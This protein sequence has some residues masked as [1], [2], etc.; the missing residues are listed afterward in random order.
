MIGIIL[1]AFTAVALRGICASKNL[2]AKASS[3]N[4]VQLSSDTPLFKNNDLTNEIITLPNGYFVKI[5]NTTG[6]LSRVEYN[7]I[8]GYIDNSS[9][10]P[11]S[12]SGTTFQTATLYTR[13]DAGTHLRIKPSATSERV[14]LIPAGSTL[15]YI[16]KTTGDIPSD[17]TS[18]EWYYV[19]FDAGDTTTHTGY[20]YSE[21]TI[22]TNISPKPTLSTI[23]TEPTI[24]TSSPQ[25]PTENEQIE[26]LSTPLSSGLKIF[27][28]ILFSVL[29]I[30]IFALLLISPKNKQTNKKVT[31]KFDITPT[32]PTKKGNI[33]AYNQPE[34]GNF[35]E[36]TQ[37]SDHGHKSKSFIAPKKASSHR[38]NIKLANLPKNKMDT[39]LPPSIA[40]YFKTE[41]ISPTNLDDELL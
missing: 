18:N 30:I 32:E 1:L 26:T 38:G 7:G 23:T 33:P 14:T 35:I 34:F 4:F 27:L 2:P 19:H 37:P 25:S 29:G 16:G 36:F 21:R 15:S 41:P 13:S 40:K 24:N 9:T 10:H 20:V 5:L 17:G 6:T 8:K 11:A 39:S 22:I 12:P 31:P 28:I 3:D